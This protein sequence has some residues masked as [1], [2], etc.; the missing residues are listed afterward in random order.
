[1]FAVLFALIGIPET[2]N[3]EI[4]ECF[5]DS[6]WQIKNNPLVHQFR[7]KYPLSSD[8]YNGTHIINKDGI[9][10]NWFWNR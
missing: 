5:R 4:I 1:M 10:D 6:N 8:G 9:G 7:A 2:F 3:S